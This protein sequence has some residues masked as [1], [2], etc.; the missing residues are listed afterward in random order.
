MVL[1]VLP[2][3]RV[4]VV[5]VDGCYVLVSKPRENNKPFGEEVGL[6]AVA[7]TSVGQV[8]YYLIRFGIVRLEGEQHMVDEQVSINLASFESEEDKA[9]E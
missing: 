9:G 8:Y 1:C 5:D 7:G 6:E 3:P 4:T 2:H